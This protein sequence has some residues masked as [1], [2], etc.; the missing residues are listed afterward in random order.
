MP[1]SSNSDR[2]LIP[3]LPSGQRIENHVLA[4]SHDLAGA[5]H[6]FALRQT[7]D[8]IR[9]TFLR[10]GSDA[11]SIYKEV[12]HVPPNRRA[13]AEQIFAEYIARDRARFRRMFST[14][15]RP[16]SRKER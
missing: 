4:K 14:P 13:E 8:Q 2:P 6:Q 10:N 1:E 11:L 7:M 15:T 3:L 9:V 12:T 16:I 5:V